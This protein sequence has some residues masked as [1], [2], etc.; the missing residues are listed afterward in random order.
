MIRR[1]PQE[2]ADFFGC[3]VAMNQ[4]GA[5][6]IF[7]EKPERQER[8]WR[9]N[10]K[11]FAYLHSK[12]IDIPYPCD[13]K[14]LY[15]PCVLLPNKNARKTHEETHEFPHQSEVYTHTEYRVIANEDES[16]L[17]ENV[18]AYLAKGWIPIGGICVNDFG[19]LQAMVR[20]IL[21]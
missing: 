1:K 4:D 18:N 8:T 7:E 14:R 20:G 21:F 17:V 6:Y 9:I 19:F 5:W 12:L 16:T 11:R 2:I 10:N 3:Y 13:W 15:E